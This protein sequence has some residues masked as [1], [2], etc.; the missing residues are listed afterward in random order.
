MKIRI[1]ITGLLTSV[2][3]MLFLTGCTQKRTNIAAT[4][5]S[6][7]S[8]AKNITKDCQGLDE[9]DFLDCMVRKPKCTVADAVRAVCILNV[10]GD[11]GKNYHQRYEYLKERGIVRDSWKLRPNQW[12]DRGTLAYMLLKT[13]GIKGGVNM[14]LFASVGLGDRRYAYREML[15]RELMEDGV[16]YNYV[17]GPELVTTVGKVD[18]YMQDTGKYSPSQEVQLGNRSQYK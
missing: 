7:K 2:V 3:I 18:R 14:F 8:S 17:S 12:I 9:L 4:Q 10:G 16:A 1:I 15:Y 5:S 11:V 13:A 6:A